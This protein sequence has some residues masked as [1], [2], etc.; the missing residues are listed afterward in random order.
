MIL[1]RSVDRV[2]RLSDKSELPDDADTGESI[3]TFREFSTVML[4]L[5][6]MTRSMSSVPKRPH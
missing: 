6:K 3:R 4:L 5:Q 1:S 2:N